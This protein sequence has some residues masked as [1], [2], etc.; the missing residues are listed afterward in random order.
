MTKLEWFKK[1]GFDKEGNTWCIF[2]EDTYS[3]KN[4]LKEL[5][6][7]FSPL[8]LW[9]SSQPLDLP[10]GYGVFELSI[11]QIATWDEKENNMIYFEKAKEIVNR[12]FKEAEGPSL[13]EYI[14]NIGD[15]LRDQTAI[16]KSTRGFSG[17]YGWT[18]IHTFEINNN[19]LVWF[20]SI[21]LDNL[22]RGQA[23]LL[24]GSIKKHETF[25]E[26]KT[27]HLTRCRVKPI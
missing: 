4:H 8:L 27:T 6:C 7:K 10:V 19:I 21:S 14:G 22:E 15:R 9:H 11:Q 20:T 2:G 5:G 23:V 24:T 3:I 18:N 12:K 25:R 13:S 16:Y 17:K 26:V 1:N